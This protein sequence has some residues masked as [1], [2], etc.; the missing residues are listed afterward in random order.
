MFDADTLVVPWFISID[1]YLS[2]DNYLKEVLKTYQVFFVQKGE[3]ILVV[4]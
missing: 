3:L 4:Q 2:A 1:L